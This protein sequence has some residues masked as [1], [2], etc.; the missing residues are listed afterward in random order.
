MGK[1]AVEVEPGDAR[2][3]SKWPSSSSLMQTMGMSAGRRAGVAGSDV[4]SCEGAGDGDGNTA[5]PP[6]RITYFGAL[7]D[8]SC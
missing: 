8:Q 4:R 1:Q 5:D 3:R 6:K 2:G 7:K